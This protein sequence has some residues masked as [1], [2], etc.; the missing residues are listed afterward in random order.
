MQAL[1]LLTRV[2]PPL[3]V[4]CMPMHFSGAF[5][6]R[7]LGSARFIGAPGSPLHARS[8]VMR[9]RLGSRKGTV[10]CEFGYT[11]KLRETGTALPGRLRMMLT[12]RHLNIG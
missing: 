11:L 8:E 12:I 5:F 3:E 4:C 1:H 10:I 7:G 9:E 6:L 2:M